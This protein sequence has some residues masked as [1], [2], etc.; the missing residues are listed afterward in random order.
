MNRFL[1][2][3][4]FS[5]IALG[6]ASAIGAEERTSSS[7]PRAE[8][9][10]RIT[11]VL[12]DTV[13]LG[14]DIFNRGNHE[15]CYR[16][17]QG[18]L[19]TLLPL[20]DHRPELKAKA[21]KKLRQAKDLRKSA[22]QAWLLREAIDEISNT[23]DRDLRA[24]TPPAKTLY[25]RLGGEA[26]IKA[27]VDDFVA[28]AA[29]N[30]KVNFTRKGTPVEWDA[31]PENVE[32]LKKHLVQLIG[33][34]TGGPQKYEGRS[35]KAAHQGMRITNAEFDALAGD[36]KATLDK[37]NVPKQEQQELFKII[38]STRDDIV[39]KK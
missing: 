14:A 17:Y 38:G 12:N 4:L 34:V 18:S 2:L 39:E 37:F 9:D 31:T 36:L 6:F 25:E 30:P 27:V 10:R 20:M 19:Q 24:K 35:M 16:L 21:E 8:L 7:L 3:F 13:N 28:R 15:G 33:M 26:A 1:R 29:G 23:L 32:K 11:D 22:D 5:V